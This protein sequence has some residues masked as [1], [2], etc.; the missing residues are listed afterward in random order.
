M[1]ARSLEIAVSRSVPPERWPAVPSLRVNLRTLSP[2][3]GYERFPVHTI[4]TNRRDGRKLAAGWYPSVM[5]GGPRVILFD[6]ELSSTQSGTFRKSMTVV[7][8]RDTFDFQTTR[9]HLGKVENIV[10]QIE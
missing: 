3:A 4:I 6:T 10:D 8:T 1:P 5:A 7:G 9:F 2:A